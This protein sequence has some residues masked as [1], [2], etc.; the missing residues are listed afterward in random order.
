MLIPSYRINKLL[1]CTATERK[2]WLSRGYLIP[3][4]YRDIHQYGK[5]LSVPYFDSDYIG[6][7]TQEDVSKWRQEIAKDHHLKR[8]KGALQSKETKN[9]RATLRVN[10]MSQFKAISEPWN[11]GGPLYYATLSLAFWTCWISKWAKSYQLIN[12]IKAQTR[13]DELYALK[14]TAVKVLYGSGFGE[15]QF[16]IP[17][18]PDKIYVHMC[19]H[20]WEMGGYDPDVAQSCK[21]C[22]YS[23]QSNYYS[24]YYLK[25]IDRYSD[26]TY[27]YHTPYIIGKRIFPSWNTLIRVQHEENYEGIFRFGRPLYEDEKIVVP[28]QAVTLFNKAYSN[29]VLLLR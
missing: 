22:K 5:I 19:D 6:R 18:S 11:D 20:H 21:H 9:E 8:V 29:L 24:L 1:A 7:I 25:V 4:E 13:K 27:S 12:S 3:A 14:N 15:L 28:C 10:Y 17:E 2:N 26:T 23:V 16:Y